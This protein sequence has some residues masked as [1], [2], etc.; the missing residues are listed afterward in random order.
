MGLAIRRLQDRLR[1]VS[2]EQ[3]HFRFSEER[4]RDL[5]ELINSRITWVTVIQGLVVLAA[6][7]FQLLYLGKLLKSKGA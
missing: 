5:S 7:G 3:S 6:A 1:D 2:Q 4:S